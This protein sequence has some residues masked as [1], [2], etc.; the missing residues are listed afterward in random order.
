[1][2]ELIAKIAESA[3]EKMKA[4]REMADI[5][6]IRLQYLGKK[7]ELTAFLRNMKD[8]PADEKPLV[9][10]LVNEA[11]ERVESR[12]EEITQRIREERVAA[13]LQSESLDITMPAKRAKRGHVHPLSHTYRKVVEIFTQM[14]FT[15]CD[16][17]HIETVFNNF[18]ALNSPA[19][20]PARAMTD[21]FYIDEDTLLRTHT[22]TVQIRVARGQTPPIRVFSVG[23][24]FRND[25]PDPTHSPM[26]YQIEGLVIDKNVS[27]TDLKG[28]LEQFAKRMFG[29]N[30]K[31][32]LRPHYFPF[33]EPSGEVD[34]SCFKCGGEG[35]RVCGSSG[36]IEILGCG[37]VHPKVLENCGIDPSEYS[38]FAFGMG[39]DR[40]NM[41]SYNVDDIRVL[42]ENDKRVLEQF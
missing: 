18:D 42:Y 30:T 14:G 1:M 13:R 37:M 34:V 25:T 3:L 27:L 36:W 23:R 17:P 12:L 5:E 15:L 38:G 22:A 2:K 35:C 20:H 4:V 7:G 33:T 29:E 19:D 9:G 39:L 8:V 41:L 40:I 32:K 11:K 6:N 10:K 26:F 28:T 16:G 21:T 24:A 31:I